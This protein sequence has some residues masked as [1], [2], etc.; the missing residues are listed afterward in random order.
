MLRD[1]HDDP[2]DPLGKVFQDRVL[3]RGKRLEELR[4]TARSDPEAAGRFEQLAAEQLKDYERL[5]QA[6]ERFPIGDVESPVA[7]F[8]SAMDRE[9]QQLRDDAKRLRSYGK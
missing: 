1:E 6:T 7:I 5:V 4:V 3:E 9:I 2:T 8:R